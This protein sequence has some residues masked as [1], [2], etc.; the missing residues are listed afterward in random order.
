M[1]INSIIYYAA[2]VG[3]DSGLLEAAKLD[4]ASKWQQIWYIIVPHLTSII[5]ILTILGIGHLFA[6]DFGLFYQV[7]KDQGVLYPATDVISTYTYRALMGG[8]LEK[9]AA[10]GLFQ[11]LSGL[12]LVVLTNT[13]VR[14]ISPEDSLF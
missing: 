13:I 5:T 4:G 2:L 3:L 11:S 9:S 1:G 7:P 14:K 6:G 12:I 8:N 10:M